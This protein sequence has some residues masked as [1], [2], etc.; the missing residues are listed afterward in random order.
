LGPSTGL[1]VLDVPPTITL[2]E[3]LQTLLRQCGVLDFPPL[4]D[5]LL[6]CAREGEAGLVALGALLSGLP[7]V[8]KPDDIE[9]AGIPFLLCARPTYHPQ[10]K[11]R[12]GDV[13]GGAQD[14]MH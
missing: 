4:P 8:Y 10:L 6:L 11:E 9:A 14:P 5:L 3:G 7:R 12:L 2:S 1:A 13:Y